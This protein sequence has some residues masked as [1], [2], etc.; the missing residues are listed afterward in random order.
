MCVWMTKFDFLSNFHL[1]WTL[2]SLIKRYVKFE[3]DLSSSYRGRMTLPKLYKPRK[4]CIYELR[5]LKGG[6]VGSH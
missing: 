6:L 2:V 4:S 5:G 3:N 1:A